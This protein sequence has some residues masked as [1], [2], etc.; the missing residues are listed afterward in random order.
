MSPQIPMPPQT[1]PPVYHWRTIHPNAT[2]HYVRDLVVANSLLN[3]L[4]G[5]VGFDLEWRPNFIKDA[6]ENPVAIVQLANETMILVIQVS[7]M[8]K[9]PMKLK[10]FLENPGV[11]KAGVAIQNDAKKLYRDW[12]VS[13]HHCVDLSLLARCADNAQ[14]KGKYSDPLGLARLVEAYESR[15]LPKGKISRSNWESLLTPLL[16]DYAANDAHAGFVLYQ[17]LS[18]MANAMTKVPKPVYYTFSLIRGYLCEPSGV[19]WICHNPDYDPG[20]PP[21]PKPPKP[22]TTRDIRRANVR[23]AARLRDTA[24]AT[25]KSKSDSVPEP[26]QG[27]TSPTSRSTQVAF[28]RRSTHRRVN[29]LPNLNSGEQSSKLTLPTSTLPTSPR[30]AQIAFIRRSTHRR[31]DSLPNLNSGEQGSTLTS[32]ISPRS[33]QIDFLRRSIQRRTDALSASNSGVTASSSPMPSNLLQVQI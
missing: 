20:P 16:V 33:A 24:D 26:L 27:S 25:L 13:V 14:W 12:Q 19:Q 15:T 17:R 28:I 7:A 32:P 5:P 23:A 9:F 4:R 6:P 2:L 21:P 8:K 22:P 1:Q 18:A 30:S 29:S 10:A 11:V 31:A 3:D